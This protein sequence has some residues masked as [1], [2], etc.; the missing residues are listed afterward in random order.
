MAQLLQTFRDN[1]TKF[2]RQHKLW[3]YISILFI[4]S[5]IVLFFSWDE[6]Q[7]VHSNL[8]VWTVGIL[9]FLTAAVW[10]IWTMLLVQKVLTHQIDVAE[11]LK[12]IT[13]DIKEI[14]SEVSDLNKK[15]LLDQ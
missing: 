11:I 8:L 2:N 14:R 9:A 4:I 7:S 12:D 15:D 1:L 10:W 13:T 6:I 5:R 3:M